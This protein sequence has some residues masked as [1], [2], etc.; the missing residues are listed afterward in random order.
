ME[1]GKGVIIVGFFLIFMG[2]LIYTFGDKVGFLGNLFGDFKY[3]SKGIK[4]FFPITSML[5]ISIISSILINL[6]IKIFK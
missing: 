6:I 3:E 1:I 2:I 5:I 4:I